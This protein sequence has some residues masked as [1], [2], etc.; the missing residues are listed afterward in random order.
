MADAGLEILFGIIGAALIVLYIVN[1]IATKYLNGD[2]IKIDEDDKEKSVVTKEQ[3]ETKEFKT[4][5]CYA[6]LCV[7]EAGTKKNSVSESKKNT[8]VSRTTPLSME[9]LPILNA[10]TSKEFHDS[11]DPYGF[12]CDA[13]L[14]YYLEYCKSTNVVSGIIMSIT[15]LDMSSPSVPNEICFYVKLA[16]NKGK[17]VA[18]T[19]WKS[20]ASSST[21][22]FALGPLKGNVDVNQGN[23]RVQLLGRTVTRTSSAGICYGE[24]RLMMST[25]FHSRNGLKLRQNLCPRKM[26]CTDRTSA[27]STD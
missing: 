19:A 12:V 25:L 5:D 14:H 13:E 18:K 6:T 1:K 21:I 23:I 2:Y 20:I 4:K 15:G 16:T 10:S 11:F 9:R 8:R 22:P 7:A 17:Y 24:C 27:F 3:R 26:L